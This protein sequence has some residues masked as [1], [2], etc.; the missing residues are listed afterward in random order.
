MSIEKIIE[1]IDEESKKLIL[2][3]AALLGTKAMIL[4]QELK[5]ST[6]KRVI[7]ASARRKMAAA[8]KKRWAAFRAKKQK[9]K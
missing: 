4:G 9:A 5:P 6:G 1:Q 2:A 3:R 8:Q 7:S